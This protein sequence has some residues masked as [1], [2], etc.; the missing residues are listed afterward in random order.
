MSQPGQNPNQNNYPQSNQPP[1]PY[2]QGNYQAPQGSYQPGGYPQ[3]QPPGQY[4]GAGYGAP[5]AY[6]VAPVKKAAN[7]LLYLIPAVGVVIMALGVFLPWF[8]LTLLGGTIG[9]NGLGN[10]SGSAE[11]T[12]LYT[13]TNGSSAAKDGVLV[14]GLAGILIVL[15][16]LGLLLKARGFAIAAIVFGV[17]AAGLMVFEVTDATR[18]INDIN[19][20]TGG[21]ASASTG[22]GLYVGLA[23]ALIVLVG[24]IIAFAFFRK[25]RARV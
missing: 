9:V 23:G 25:S 11:L 13:Q 14:L 21:A 15:I 4:Q 16:V 12:A 17:M 3:P 7:P 24:A 22:L 19:R 20:T 6:G 18:S 2:N 5:P 1:P 10:V 8:N